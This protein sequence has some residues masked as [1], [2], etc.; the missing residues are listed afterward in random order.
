[1]IK[2]DFNKNEVGFHV[3]ISF[4]KPEK[5]KIHI[6]KYMNA[7]R[8]CIFYV[9]IQIGFVDLETHYGNRTRWA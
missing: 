9:S 7:L 1:M 8:I 2:R 4:G 5:F 3:Y 6:R